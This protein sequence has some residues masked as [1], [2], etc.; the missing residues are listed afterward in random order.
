MA[1]AE[2]CTKPRAIFRLASR[3]HLPDSRLCSHR[4]NP[5]ARCRDLC[6]RRPVSTARALDEELGSHRLCHRHPGSPPQT[7]VSRHRASTPRCG[8]RAPAVPL[9]GGA[10]RGHTACPRPSEPAHLSPLGSCRPEPPGAGRSRSATL[11][12][13][14]RSVGSRGS[15]RPL[16]PAGVPCPSVSVSR[17]VLTPPSSLLGRLGALGLC[18]RSEPCRLCTRKLGQGS[19]HPRRGRMAVAPSARR[20]TAAAGG[21]RA[22]AQKVWAPATAG[23]RSFCALQRRWDTGIRSL[24]WH[25]HAA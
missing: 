24:P 11:L 2:E 25:E 8:T 9:G 1:D 13:R 20:P 16:P 5:S 7:A 22:T 23:C 14:C 18:R 12:S 15:R 21:A 19:A 17:A 3:W 4:A 10:C 6:R